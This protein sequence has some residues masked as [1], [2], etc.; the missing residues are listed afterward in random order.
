MH[1][2]FCVP[3][4]ERKITPKDICSFYQARKHVELTINI[5]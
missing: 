1:T 4:A 5:I 3:K 2:Y